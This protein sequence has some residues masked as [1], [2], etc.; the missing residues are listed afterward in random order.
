MSVNISVSLDYLFCVTVL[1]KTPCSLFSIPAWQPSVFTVLKNIDNTVESADST[2]LRPCN[3]TQ[4]W[5]DVPGFLLFCPILS[6][7]RNK[8]NHSSGPPQSRRTPPPRKKLPET[9]NLSP[10][11]WSLAALQLN[12]WS[13]C[14]QP[15]QLLRQLKKFATS[16]EAFN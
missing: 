8:C 10:G 4:T 7:A 5:Q 13:R 1:K 12:L 2:R 16:F 14:C 15:C 11:R 6:I 9:P 3:C